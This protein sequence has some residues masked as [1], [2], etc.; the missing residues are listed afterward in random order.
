MTSK[1][2]PTRQRRRVRVAAIALLLVATAAVASCGKDEKSGLT[3]MSGGGA[4]QDALDKAYIRPFERENGVRVFDDPTLS[5][6]KV[7]S[8]VES[9]GSGVDVI[10][11]EGF[12]AVQ[13]CGKLLQPIDTSVV[14]TSAIDPALK[15]T[16]CGAPLLTYTSAIYYK[17]ASYKGES[18]PT[19]CRDFFDVARFPG[20][21]AAYSGALPNPLLEC[22]LIADGVPRA[23][24]YPLDLDRAFKKIQTIKDKLV[25]WN[26][27]ADSAQLMTAGEVDM[28]LAWN[29]RAYAGIQEQKAAYTPAHGDEFLHYDALV[30]P[31]GVKDTAQAMKL[32]AYMMD[33]Q[34]QAT[35][36]TL[37]PYAPANKKA[38]LTNLP[39]GLDAYLPGTN[40]N[41][42]AALIVQDQRWW[43]EN[44]DTVT[45]RWQQTFNG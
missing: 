45:T 28:I 16:E 10:P 21:R 37:I 44:A 43:A 31:K 40:P 30:V 27:G 42:A 17:N 29:G 2:P 14:D 38:K 12:W 18:K 36:T 13:Q 33:P 22:A 8:M 7:Q 15:Q 6:A 23:S 41:V 24:L 25:V 34:R 4:Y 20:K 1:V 3:F 11:A 9:G 35:L 5:Y 26:S 39:A 19:G 32:V